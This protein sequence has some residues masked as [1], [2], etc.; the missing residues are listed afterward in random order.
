MRYFYSY[1]TDIGEICLAEENGAIINLIFLNPTGDRKRDADQRT[2]RMIIGDI[3]EEKETALI[4]K[5]HGQLQEYLAGARRE[6]E[7]PLSPKGTEFQRKVWSALMEIPY[8]ERRSYKDIALRIGN[9]KACRAVGLANN[10]NPISVFVP[11]HRVVGSTGKL[12]GYGGGLDIK[13]KLL[14]LEGTRLLERSE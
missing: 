8:G 7:L 3:S 5:A 12:V 11:C 1:K 4:G 10:R 6:F 2:A 14:R 13:E 9:E